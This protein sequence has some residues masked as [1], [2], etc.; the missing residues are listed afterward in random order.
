M[1]LWLAILISL[2]F[3]VIALLMLWQKPVADPVQRY[4]QQFCRK[5]AQQGIEHSPYEGPADF[6]RRASA[7]LPEKQNEIRQIS[8]YY[9]RLRYA[10][11]PGLLTT[12]IDAVKQFS[13]R[14]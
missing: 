2:L 7:H 5:L 3:T 4:Y 1:A 14:R 11:D 10:N 6:A 8:D 12:F 13:A 9:R